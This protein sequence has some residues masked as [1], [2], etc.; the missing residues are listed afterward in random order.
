MGRWCPIIPV[1]A[2]STSS[3]L[4]FRCLD[5]RSAIVSAS[6]S[7]FLPVHAFALPLFTTIACALPF[8]TTFLL[9]FIGAATIWFVVK[10]AAVLHGCSEKMMP[11]SW[12]F[13]SLFRPQCTEPTLKPFGAI[14][15]PGI[16]LIIRIFL[17]KDNLLL[18]VCNKVKE[19]IQRQ[20]QL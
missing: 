13:L 9:S 18:Q 7:P 4:I 19:G 5:V 11:I 3:G 14:T 2:T 1:E 6:F 15:F 20:Q 10:R 17:L 8:F 12:F 16:V